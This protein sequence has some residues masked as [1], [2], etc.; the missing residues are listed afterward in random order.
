MAYQK[1]DFQYE[2]KAKK[3][4]AV[5]GHTEL[6]WM[7]FKDNLTA[8]NGV[9]KG[10]FDNK[11][12]INKQIAVMIFRHLA[13]QGI[14]SHLL[15]DISE[16]EFVCQKVAIIPLEV[17]VRNCLAGSTAQKFALAEGFSLEKPL[18]EFY[19]K[20]DELNDPFISDDQA[21]ML[22]AVKDQEQ[23][24]QLKNQA[25]QVNR[26]LMEFFAAIGIRLVDFKLEFGFNAKGDLVLADEITP[27]SCRLWDMKTNKKLDKDR[28]RRDL[29]QVE[30]S[31]Q[32]ILNRMTGYWENQ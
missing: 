25:L 8:F 10:T 2:G 18:V 14:S 9:K 4:F 31:Y 27:D 6:V 20:K 16:R 13:T 19:Y 3:L 12:A 1:G 5:E 26:A 17:V 24:D 30:E 28:F 32:E 21:L 15:K 11:G 22:K 23:L 7:E 29:G